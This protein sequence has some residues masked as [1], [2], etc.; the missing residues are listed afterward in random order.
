MHR[1]NFYVGQYPLGS[2][3]SRLFEH[4]AAA[5]RNLPNASTKGDVSTPV[6]MTKLQKEEISPFRCAAVDMTNRTKTGR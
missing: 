1:R 5:P 3:R 4:S 2:N 6:D